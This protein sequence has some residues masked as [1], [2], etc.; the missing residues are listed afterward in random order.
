MKIS[1]FS[2]RVDTL[3]NH[4]NQIRNYV[5]EW[6]LVLNEKGYVKEKTLA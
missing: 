3:K 6:Y 4:W 1:R 2:V 5:T